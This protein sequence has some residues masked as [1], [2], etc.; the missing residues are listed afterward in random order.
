MKSDRLE[1]LQLNTDT[2][3]VNGS[4]ILG[5]LTGPCADIINPTRN[6]RKYTESLWEKVFNDPIVKEHFECG[7]IFGELGHPI[8][9][10]ETDM[11]KIAICMPE[12]PK[13]NDK[14]QLIGSWDILDTPN[15]RIAYALAKYG[16]K[17]GIS[18]RG[19]GD[20]YTDPNG[21][22]VVDEDTYDFQAF[23]LV[24]LPAVK[25]ARLSMAES[26]DKSKLSFKKVI[27]EE[28]N[29][30][31]AD[32]RRIM[33]ETL[34]SLNIDYSQPEQV[35]YNTGDVQSSS[36]DNNGVQMAKQLQEALK[37]NR[38]LE[39]QV[40]GLQEKL[41]VGI[42][43]ENRKEAQLEQYKRSIAN[44][45]EQL[46]RANASEK[47]LES[48]KEH[49]SESVKSNHAQ[50]T[51]LDNLKGKLSSS[52][53]HISTL[54]EK[55]QSQE[56]YIAELKGKIHS[57]THQLDEMK[58]RDEEEKSKL[59]ESVSKIKSASIQKEKIMDAKLQ[60]SNQLVE[61]YKKVAQTAVNKYI[62]SQA[63]RLGVNESDIKNQ[64]PENY[65]FDDIDNICESLMNY[66][67][68]M[69]NLPFGVG[70]VTQLS[71]EKVKMNITESKERITPNRLIDDEVDE[72]LLNL[73]N[74]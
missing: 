24:L 49:Y 65:S 54:N 40:H 72:Q 53:R 5:K 31:N 43:K 22:E 14:G 2:K 26:L 70:S 7:G 37:Q 57:L 66:R 45:T 50:E 13:K 46:K 71:K 68:G 29:K 25:S 48:L 3:S 32:D 36:A 9:R 1:D 41:S 47:K 52:K 19:T 74:I 59:T 44:L 38:A 10:S 23:Y 33:T 51:K 60:K 58:E 56:D 6:D 35:V 28:L 16:Y 20:V 27:C 42:T 39:K 21:E 55:V 17:L 62:K 69:S 4:V 15:G 67:V 12:P 34:N 18:S 63:T 8:D 11:E 73:A 30:A 61:K 64:L